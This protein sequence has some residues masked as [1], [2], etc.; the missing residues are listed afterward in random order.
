MQPWGRQRE[1]EK[2][3]IRQQSIG[4]LPEH[5]QDAA[6]SRTEHA[7]ARYPSV[8]VKGCSLHVCEMDGDWEV[9]LNN[10]DHDFTGLCLSVSRRRN[11]AIVE[12]V[13]ILEAAV[14]ELLKPPVRA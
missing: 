5:E 4:S 14:K 1:V 12:A 2:L 6:S 11:D 3:K 8:P 13:E 7:S 10:Q 9:W